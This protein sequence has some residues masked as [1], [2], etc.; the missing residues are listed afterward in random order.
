MD[1]F[2]VYVINTLNIISILLPTAV[3]FKGS[4]VSWQ[5]AQGPVQEKA[6]PV[7]PRADWSQEG[8]ALY[9]SVEDH[10]ESPTLMDHTFF[11][12]IMLFCTQLIKSSNGISM[13]SFHISTPLSCFCCWLSLVLSSDLIVAFVLVTTIWFGSLYGLLWQ[14][15][16]YRERQRRQRKT[17]G[18]S[19]TNVY[20][21]DEKAL[22]K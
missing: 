13:D 5:S 14:D 1:L 20:L 9:N 7:L 8:T 15:Y 11:S 19:A 16:L 4:F 21:L 10:T 3:W 18:L 2:S 12:L 17:L 22:L 6:V